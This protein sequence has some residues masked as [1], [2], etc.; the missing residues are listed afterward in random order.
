MV[1]QNLKFTRMT[2]GSLIG[3]HPWRAG[4]GRKSG[5]AIIAIERGTEVFTEFDDASIIV[6]G[7]YAVHL[8]YGEQSGKV[9][10]GLRRDGGGENLTQVR[11]TQA[12][13]QLPKR[14]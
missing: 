12:E 14:S 5:A 1:E 6:A 8:R 9:C 3:A 13:R 2:A 7:R 4:T 11:L 10:E